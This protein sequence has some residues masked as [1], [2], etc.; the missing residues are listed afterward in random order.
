MKKIANQHG[1]VVLEKVQSIPAEAKQLKA[2]HGFVVEKGEGV[3]T[4][5][6]KKV[7][8]CSKTAESPLTLK[9]ISEDVEIW[10]L[11]DT[12]FI[13]VKKGGSVVIDH[14]EHGKQVLEPG[15][16]KK[17]IEREYD[18]EANEERRVID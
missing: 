10:A 14:E 1:D 9:D 3:H 11:N 13:K 17:N 4:H 15:I 8:P 18:Y 7:M 16:Y 2:V 12:M 5:V 6:L